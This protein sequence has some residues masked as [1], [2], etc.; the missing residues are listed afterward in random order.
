[1]A[2]EALSGLAPEQLADLI[3]FVK[4]VISAFGGLITLYLIISIWKFIIT[5]KNQ[6]LLLDMQ[7]DIGRIKRKLKIN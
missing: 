3:S 4:G 7:K 1:M 2:L 5:R 6:K